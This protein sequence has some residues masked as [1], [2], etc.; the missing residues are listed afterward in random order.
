ME[1]RK[2]TGKYWI[3]FFLWLVLMI[4]MLISDDARPFFWLALPGVCTHFAMAM[5]IM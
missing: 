5:D 3:Y 2:S 1:A 4:V